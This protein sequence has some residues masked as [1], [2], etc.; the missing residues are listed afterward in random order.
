MK[1]RVDVDDNGGVENDAESDKSGIFTIFIRHA[2][3]TL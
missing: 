1:P 2:L 3:T